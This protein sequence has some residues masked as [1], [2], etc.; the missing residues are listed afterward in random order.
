[1]IRTAA[2]PDEDVQQRMPKLTRAGSNA[3]WLREPAT[4]QRIQMNCGVKTESL[5]L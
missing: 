4:C 2:D 3:D 1:M 5:T